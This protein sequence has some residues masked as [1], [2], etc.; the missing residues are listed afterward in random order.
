MYPCTWSPLEGCY[1][2][3]G[4]PLNELPSEGGQAAAAFDKARLQ[5]LCQGLIGC[6]GGEGGNHWPGHPL[7]LAAPCKW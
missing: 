5:L 6:H 4:H 1:L 2:S 7:A 3:A